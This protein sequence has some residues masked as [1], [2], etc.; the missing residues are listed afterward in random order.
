MCFSA[1][2]SFGAS[3]ILGVM[4]AYALRKAKQNELF[5]ALI[6]ILFSIQQACEGIVWITYAN[7]NYQL[8]TTAATYSFCFFAFFFWPVWIPVTIL[9]METNPH[10]KLV[11]RALLFL[12][13]FIAS[14]LVFTMLT[15]GIH[16]TVSCSHIE[17]TIFLPESLETIGAVFYCITTILPP[18]LSSR[19]WLPFF[20]L[21]TLGSV[22]ITY[23]FYSTYF[24]SVW[25]FFA[26]L[27]S[28][29]IILI[30]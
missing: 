11:L 5:L 25:C 1:Q 21:L 18:L 23:F 3:A 7:P 26:A 29:V 4:G 2:A 30:L 19:K 10:K 28:S 13:F 22:G 12:G 6:P 20:G 8:I 16:T 24:T 27:L 15:N 9:K 14:I 17:Y